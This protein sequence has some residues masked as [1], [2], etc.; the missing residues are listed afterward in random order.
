MRR[1]TLYPPR[2]PPPLR[3]FC[4]SRTVDG[5]MRAALPHLI[6]SANLWSLRSQKKSLR[7]EGGRRHHRDSWASER[8]EG[9]SERAARLSAQPPSALPCVRPPAPV[10]IH[11]KAAFLPSLLPPLFPAPPAGWLQKWGR[12]RR[13]EENGRR[14]GDLQRVWR[15]QL[16]YRSLG[17]EGVDT[18]WRHGRLTCHSPMCLWRYACPPSSALRFGLS[19]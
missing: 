16:A 12:G 13:S 7:G 2:P 17:V 15:E 11:C 3:K 10:R 8:R 1:N 4:R 6:K 18:K 14:L 19:C 9:E 5:I